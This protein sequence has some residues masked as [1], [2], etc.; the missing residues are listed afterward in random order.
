MPKTPIRVDELIE[1]GPV[2]CRRCGRQWSH[3][4]I[5]EIKGIRQLRCG[6]VLLPAATLICLHDGWKFTWNINEE[7]IGQ[8]AVTYGN[9]MREIRVYRPE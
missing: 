2:T 4:A 1:T 7:K 8:M 6:D 9:L 5:E 3:F